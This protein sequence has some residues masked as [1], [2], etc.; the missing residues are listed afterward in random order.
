MDISSLWP[1]LTEGG[2]VCLCSVRGQVWQYQRH[3]ILWVI[4]Y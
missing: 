4:G 2:Q 3:S 1:D